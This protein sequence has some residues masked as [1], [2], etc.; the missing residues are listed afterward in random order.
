MPTR[1]ERPYPLTYDLRR[2]DPPVTALQL[3]KQ[4]QRGDDRG[5]CDAAI[6]ISIVYPQDGGVSHMILSRDG[7]TGKPLDDT[8]L[9]KAW[10]M[11]ACDL[12]R[13]RLS[14]ELKNI[15]MD[16]FEKI[17]RVVLRDRKGPGLA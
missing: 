4:A 2:E 14:D 5:A 12:A 3:E 9:F 13:G 17:R 16:A 8:E 7:R 1:D 6:L 11:M 10:S 15:C